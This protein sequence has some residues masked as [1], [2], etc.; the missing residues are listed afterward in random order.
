MIMRKQ[1]YEE[2]LPGARLWTGDMEIEADAIEQIRNVT[3]L[4]ILAGPV[5]VM[6]DVHLGRGRDRRNSDSNA[7]RH[8]AGGRSAWTSAAECS[9]SRR[10][11]LP[12]IFPKAWSLA[13]ADRARRARGI[14]LP[15]TAAGAR[16]FEGSAHPRSR[17]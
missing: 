11:L 15:Q 9:P 7:R 5:V 10:T 16:R 13:R 17:A 6:P 1:T 14:Q 3:Q 2:M 12:G 8:R 4:P